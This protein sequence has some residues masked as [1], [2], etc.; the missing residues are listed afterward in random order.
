MTMINSPD[1]RSIPMIGW[2]V[3]SL[4]FADISSRARA[5]VLPA[6]RLVSEMASPRG[7]CNR[8]AFLHIALGFLALQGVVASLFWLFGTEMSRESSLAL[9][10]PLL[11]IGTTVCVKRLHDTGRRGWWLPAA[12]AV[13]LLV[14]MVVST[15]AAIVL[16]AEAMDDGQPAYLAVIVAITLPA[17]AALSW[18]HTVSSAPQSNRF[19]PVPTGFGLSRPLAARRSRQART[20]YAD[21]VLA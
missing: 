6:L 8:Q 13:W 5:T 11:W 3:G 21:A 20:Y 1:L 18:L 9:N 7:R 16:P 12:F 14:A 15:V 19:G 4:D 17:F 2:P 10:A